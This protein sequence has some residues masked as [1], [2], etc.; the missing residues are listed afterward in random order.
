[1]LDINLNKAE[2]EARCCKVLIV[3]ILDININIHRIATDDE[4]EY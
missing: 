4:K 1:M 3:A 2:Y